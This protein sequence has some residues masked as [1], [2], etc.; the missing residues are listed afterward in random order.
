MDARS[1]LQAKLASRHPTAGPERA[2]V[3][4]R[5]PRD[6]AEVFKRTPYGADLQ[7]GGRYVAKEMFEVRHVPLLLRTLLDQGYSHGEC[8]TVPGRTV[9]E[10]LSRA[11]R[12]K[13]QGVVRPVDKPLSASGGVVGLRGNRAPAG[14]VVAGMADLKF[15]GPA[16]CF[17]GEEA[18]LDA[19]K[20]KKYREG[21]VLVIR[22]EEPKRGSGMRELPAIAAARYRMGGRIALIT[23]GGCS[24]APRGL[25][26]QADVG[27]PIAHFCDRDIILIDAVTATLDIKLS[28][29]EL[30][31]R[32]QARRQACHAGI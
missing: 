22:Y 25:R 28:S 6:A 13:D 7:P 2:P 3:S 1:N 29:A 4:E 31:S 27:G 5:D 30:N 18:R 24:Q 26:P 11:K 32:R 17:D 14:A 23:D 19:V 10:N 9:S 12:N 20:K 8:L 16:R 21:D 15:T